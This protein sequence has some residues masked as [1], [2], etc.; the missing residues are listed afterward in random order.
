MI[1]KTNTSQNFIGRLMGGT[2]LRITER[3]VH[4]SPAL[5][6]SVHKRCKDQSGINVAGEEVIKIA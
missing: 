6:T 2:L 4:S 1:S 3:I 5:M